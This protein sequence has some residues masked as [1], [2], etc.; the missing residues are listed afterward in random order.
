METLPF[1]VV[2]PDDKAE[3]DE[4]RLFG[5]LRSESKIGLKE[6]P[7]E[8]LK[9]NLAN[10]S[11]SMIKVL[12]DVKHIGQFRLKEIT[13]QVEVSSEGGINLIGTVNLGGKGAITLT[14]AE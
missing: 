13:L 11:R 12:E 9:N 3:D 10:I 6:I 7:L 14:F 1:I 8:V 2:L 4:M 5:S